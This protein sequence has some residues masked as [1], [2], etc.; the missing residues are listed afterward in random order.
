MCMYV[1]IYVR[2]YECV[3]MYVYMYVSECVSVHVPWHTYGD[4]L[5]GVSS[6]FL[7][8]ESQGINLNHQ[9]SKP[10]YPGVITLDY[11]PVTWFLFVSILVIDIGT[12][13]HLLV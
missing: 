6:V 5:A 12:L 11:E 9:V 10:L 8:C 7:L 4:K 13:L 1:C 2:V 3:C